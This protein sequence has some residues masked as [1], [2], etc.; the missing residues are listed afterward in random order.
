MSSF[1]VSCHLVFAKEMQFVHGAFS[2]VFADAMGGDFLED[3][4][5]GTILALQPCTT[6][7]IV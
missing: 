4:G 6:D 7:L 2:L 1:Y 5:P 3:V